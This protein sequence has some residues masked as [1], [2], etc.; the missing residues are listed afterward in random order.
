[1]VFDGFSLRLGQASVEVTGEVF[2]V[3]TFF[4]GVSL[5]VLEDPGER[6]HCG[7][8][9]PHRHVAVIGG[10]VFA[11]PS[12]PADFAKLF[13]QLPLINH[14]AL[15]SNRLAACATCQAVNLTVANESSALCKLPVPRSMRK[16]HSGGV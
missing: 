12:A 11:L 3:I 6:G 16:T 9:D 2:V 14:V 10:H 4:V 5:R 15:L 13:F 1:M 7:V 8:A